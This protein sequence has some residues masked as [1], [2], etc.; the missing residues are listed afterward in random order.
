MLDVGQIGKH[1]SVELGGFP[2]A[3]YHDD[4]WLGRVGLK[5]ILRQGLPQVACIPSPQSVEI[6]RDMYLAI[7]ASL[8]RRSSEVPPDAPRLADVVGDDDV[9][10]AHPAGHDLHRGPIIAGLPVLA[11]KSRRSLGRE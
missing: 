2:G 4:L 8:P 7:E 11:I 6:V 3:V 5:V 1:R 9:A 10:V